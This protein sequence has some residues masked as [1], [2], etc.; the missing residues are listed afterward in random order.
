MLSSGVSALLFF[1][2]SLHSVV[3]CNIY[4]YFIRIMVGLPE[5]ER[6]ES[7]FRT[8]IEKQEGVNTEINFKELAAMTEGYTASDLKVVFLLYQLRGHFPLN[9]RISLTIVFTGRTCA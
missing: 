3:H 8:S 5:A 6:R 4:I 7:I 2:S 1:S 9:Y